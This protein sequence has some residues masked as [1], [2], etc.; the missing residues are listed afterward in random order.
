MDGREWSP[1]LSREPSIL[2]APGKLHDDFLGS[3]LLI[4]GLKLGQAG[5]AHYALRSQDSAIPWRTLAR[6]ARAEARLTDVQSI[7]G[8][9]RMG[10]IVQP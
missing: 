3:V 5:Y 4:V 2:L 10:M 6:A 7:D 1:Q 8:C 9:H